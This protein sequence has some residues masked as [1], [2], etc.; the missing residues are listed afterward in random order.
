MRRNNNIKSII[1]VLAFC[2]AGIISA[3]AQIYISM[4][5]HDHVRATSGVTGNFVLPDMPEHGS[6]LDFTPIGSGLWLLGGLAGAYLLN[7]RRKK[8]A[9]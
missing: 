8:D 1:L 3:N 2:L 4:D 5:D 9:E 7:K 6:T